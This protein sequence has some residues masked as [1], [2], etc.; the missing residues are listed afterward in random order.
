MA[1][2][3]IHGERLDPSGH[4]GDERVI[5]RTQTGEEI[6]GELVIIQRLTGGGK[7]SRYVF[8]PLEVGGDGGRPFLG[9]GQLIVQI[10]G[11]SSDGGGEAAIQTPPKLMGSAAFKNLGQHIFGDGG[12]KHAED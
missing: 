5:F 11:P 9:G 10:E 3:I 12:E 8:E 4:R 1:K 7:C 6:R 2:K